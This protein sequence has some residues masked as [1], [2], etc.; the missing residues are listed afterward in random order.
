MILPP[1]INKSKGLEAALDALGY[2]LHNCVAVGD[3]EKSTQPC[4]NRPN[5]P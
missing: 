5:V 2:S 1:G 3:A 4:C